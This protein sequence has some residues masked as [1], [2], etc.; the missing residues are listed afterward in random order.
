MDKSMKGR[1]MWQRPIREGKK[2][3]KKILEE[4]LIIAKHI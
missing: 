4:D 3:E 1:P 2:K